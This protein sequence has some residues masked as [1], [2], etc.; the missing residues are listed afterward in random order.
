MRL[1]IL[2][3]TSAIAAE[4]ARSYA[5]SGAALFLVGRD[6]ARLGA[7][8]VELA[9]LGAQQVETSRL[10]ATD[11]DA[12]QSVLDAA[13][14]ALGGLDAALIAYGVLP[15][16]QRAEQDI[17][18]AVESFEINATS[19]IAWLLR[20]ANYFEKERRG[21]IAVISSVAGDRGRASNFVYGA[22]K[23]A[24]NACLEGLRHR[25]AGSDVAVVTIKPGLVATPM[26]AHLPQNALFAH[27]RRV[28]RAVRRAID[29]RHAVSYVPW[30]WRPI[31]AVVR[32]LPAAIFHRTRL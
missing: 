9:G 23:S 14:A 2:G 30:F 25:L 31:M 11:L 12:H 22:A 26:T 32:A 6:E 5:E 1:L 3:A 18:Y 29:R 20:L 28:G 24:V 4:T 10:E 17:G 15:D 13:I 7:L 19:T 21:T 8:R 27:A 16:Q